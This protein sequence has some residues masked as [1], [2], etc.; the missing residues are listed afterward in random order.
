MWLFVI[1]D[2]Y[3]YFELFA[4]LVYHFNSTLQR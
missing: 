2:V 4:V 3:Y 1:N